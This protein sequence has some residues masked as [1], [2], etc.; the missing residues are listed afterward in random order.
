M[1]N[2]ADGKTIT[3]HEPPSKLVDGMIRKADGTNWNP[4]A[5]AGT[6]VYDAGTNT[7]TKL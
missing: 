3:L 1:N 2:L 4:G 6:Y 7:W 5:G